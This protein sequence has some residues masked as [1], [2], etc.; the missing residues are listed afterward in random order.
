VLTLVLA[1]LAMT[2]GTA[3]RGWFLTGAA[4]GAVL[5][6]IAEGRS[7]AP[8]VD[9]GL[10]RE[11]VLAAGF[12]MS[13]LATTVVMATLVVGPFYLSGVLGFGAGRMGLAMAAGPVVAA[14]AG[15][16]A[17]R[18]VD[19]YGVRPGIF[20]GLLAMEL[21]ACLLWA[22]PPATAGAWI[23]SLAVL[24]AGY[25][26]FQAANNTAVM[27]TAP[28]SGRGLVSGL[29]NLSRNLGLIAGASA[30]GAVFLRAGGHGQQQA[31]GVEGLR[32]CFG[33]AS[34]LLC[35]AIAAAAFVIVLQ[36]RE[37]SS[38]STGGRER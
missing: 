12:A 17:G 22:V 15:I 26:L 11:P 37:P 14:V 34:F 2:A 23:A 19:R 33:L 29:L 25:A 35:L 8:L 10:F 20:A 16:P 13:L 30:M 28:A 1:S 36:A 6:A 3:Q 38:Y 4:A 32:A 24:T 21:G 31:A 7:R 5:F 9:L 18:A 27:A